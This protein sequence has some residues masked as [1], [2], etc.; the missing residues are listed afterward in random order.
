MVLFYASIS[1]GN[2]KNNL[3]ES[4]DTKRFRY[5]IDEIKE[6]A[7]K[8]NIKSLGNKGCYRQTMLKMNIK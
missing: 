5:T 1:I 6:L 7:P 4:N 8:W 2:S 3:L